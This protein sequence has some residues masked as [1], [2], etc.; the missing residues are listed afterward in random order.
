[1]SITYD[2]YPTLSNYSAGGPYAQPGTV[3]TT[4]PTLSATINDADSATG[5]TGSFEIYS[6][7]SCSGTAVVTS[8]GMVPTGGVASGEDVTWAVP[9]GH[10]S[11][12]TTY[13]H[14]EGSDGTA[15][16][17]WSPC[18]TLTIDTT[19]PSTAIISL[20]GVTVEQLEHLGR[21]DDRVVQ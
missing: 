15:T 7:S 1:M 13:W 10:L 5:L 12:G 14:V 17:T 4:T 21:F 19:A 11:A 9:S 2:A 16:T 6:S 3:N 18:Q 20:T 8:G